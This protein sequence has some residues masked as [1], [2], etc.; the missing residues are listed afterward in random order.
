MYNV[1]QNETLIGQRCEENALRCVMQLR[2]IGSVPDSITKW[3]S[4]E[5]WDP[6]A[7]DLV[8]NFLK[9]NNAPCELS[10]G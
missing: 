8:D 2:E 1:I 4:C 7:I 5:M 10:N 6:S 9:I 3:E